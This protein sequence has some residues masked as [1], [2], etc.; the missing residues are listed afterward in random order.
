MTERR[1]LVTIAGQVQEL[2]AGD[3][4][5]GAGGLPVGGTT[6]QVLTKISATDGDANWQSESLGLGIAMRNNIFHH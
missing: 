2:P 5:P 3:S 6:G 1:P 4:L